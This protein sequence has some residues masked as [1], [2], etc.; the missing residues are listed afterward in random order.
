[1]ITAMSYIMYVQLVVISKYRIT[2]IVNV[3]TDITASIGESPTESVLMY[4]E[5]FK[6]DVFVFI[7]GLLSH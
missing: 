3:E 6:T 1:M 4:V 5:T 7:T 2:A